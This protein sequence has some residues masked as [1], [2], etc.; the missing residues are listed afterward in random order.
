MRRA[1]PRRRG[2]TLLELLVGL[3]IVGLL[4]LAAAPSFARFIDLQRLRSISAELVTDIQF[5]RTEAA[6][7][8]VKVALKFDRSGSAV[9]CYVVLTGDHSLCDCNQ[10]PGTGVCSGSAQKE[11]RTVQV[12]RSLGVVVGVPSSQGS[13][14]LRFDPA[15]GRIEIATSDSFA[16]PTR[17]F[18]IE[19]SNPSV[20]SLVTSIEATGRPTTCSPNG[21]IS[22]VPACP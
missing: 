10:T 7:R 6:S 2:L 14:V 17:P 11:I 4:V 20:G 12:P 21:Q 3:A 22:G 15:T 5:V 18:Q 13:S 9:S 16:P 1:A 19:V 8:N